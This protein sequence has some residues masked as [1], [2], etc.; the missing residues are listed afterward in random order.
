MSFPQVG[1][2]GVQG[3]VAWCNLILGTGAYAG[4][5]EAYASIYGTPDASIYFDNDPLAFQFSSS[6]ALTGAVTFDIVA[7]LYAPYAT[8]VQEI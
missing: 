4:Q 8:N 2:T 7:G 1:D 6:V 5:V 3:Q